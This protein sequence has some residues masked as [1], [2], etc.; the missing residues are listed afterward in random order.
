MNEAQSDACID[1]MQ[2]NLMQAPIVPLS[3]RRKLR[4]NDKINHGQSE[5][6]SCVVVVESISTSTRRHLQYVV[7]DEEIKGA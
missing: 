6:S 4:N 5:L 1:I 2:D 7:H 3:P